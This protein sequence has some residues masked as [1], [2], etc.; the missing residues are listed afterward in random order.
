MNRHTH[1]SRNTH[2]HAYSIWIGTHTRINRH[3]HDIDTP[4]L[5]TSKTHTHMNRH[6]HDMDPHMHTDDKYK[7]THI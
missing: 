6:T 2:E 7:G 5:G 1:M 4:S 3:T